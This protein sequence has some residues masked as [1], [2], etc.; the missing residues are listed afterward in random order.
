MLI[1]VLEVTFHIPS[2]QS[3]KD[4]RKVVRSVKDRIRRRFNVSLAEIEGQAAWQ[5]CTLAAAMVAAQRIAVE[6]ELNRV[7]DLIESEPSIETV[8]Q[9]IDFY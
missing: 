4:K 2:A 8:E 9:W 3:L 7:L 6:R 1:G 5:T